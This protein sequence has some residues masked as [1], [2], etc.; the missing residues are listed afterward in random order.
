[1][2]DRALARAVRSAVADAV[3]PAPWLEHRV[4]AAVRDDAAGRRPRQSVFTMPKT[5][6]AVVAAVLI[7]VLA[8]GVL[9][10]SRL[11]QSPRPAPASSPSA[12]PAVVRYR[13]M[14]EA[15]V[16][17]IDGAYGAGMA[18]SARQICR[19]QVIKMRTKTQVLV[20]DLAATPAPDRIRV[21]AANIQQASQRLLVELDAAII[22]M[23]DPTSDFISILYALN[24]DSLDFAAAV[25][26]CWPA[27]PYVRNDL[28]SGY[29][30]TPPPA[31]DIDHG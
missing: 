11:V 3:P 20:D 30:C 15:D 5:I 26:D 7:T 29:G 10:E 13:N 8:V 1:M 28:L 17:A 12:E 2:S 22:A 14:T 19:D 6:V 31:S 24:T 21:Q 9:Y 23:G 18:C 27:T 25:V 4:I 16:N